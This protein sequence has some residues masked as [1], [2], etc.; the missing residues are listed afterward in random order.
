[1]IIK[2]SEKSLHGFLERGR[3]SGEGN[4]R[5][6]EGEGE[7]VFYLWEFLIDLVKKAKKSHS[8]NR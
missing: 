5:Q 6:R 3:E 2:D 1:M 4:E 7:N 8:K